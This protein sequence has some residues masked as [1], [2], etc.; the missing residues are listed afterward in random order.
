MPQR[1]NDSGGR[2]PPRHPLPPSQTASRSS[3]S[4]CQPNSPDLS[5]IPSLSVDY[6]SVDAADPDLKLSWIQCLALFGFNPRVPDDPRFRALA[7]LKAL[8]SQHGIADVTWSDYLLAISVYA[9]MA[10]RKARKHL[11]R[12]S[13]DSGSDS[14]AQ[15]LSSRGLDIPSALK[16]PRRRLRKPSR[17]SEGTAPSQSPR[18]LSLS[19]E[20]DSS[21]PSFTLYN[22]RWSL[23]E[24][25]DPTAMFDFPGIFSGRNSNPN[26]DESLFQFDTN[27]DAPTRIRAEHVQLLYH[28]LR[29][30]ESIYGL[31]LNVASAPGV[32]LTKVTDLGII[33][34][35]TGMSSSDILVSQFGNQAF[36][37]AHYVAVDRQIKAVVVCVRGTANLVDSLTDVAATHDPFKIRRENSKGND[38]LVE[39]FGHAGI[40]RSARNLFN[41]IR[42]DVLNAIHQNPGFEL[43]TTGHSL[44]ASTA[45]VLSLIMRDDSEFPRATAVCIAPPPCMTY[46]LAEQTASSTITVVNGSDIVPRLSVAVMLPYF[47]TARY[48]ADLSKSRKALLGL[49]LV[50]ST[51]DWKELESHNSSRV[52]DLKKYHDGR[53][54][55]I[56]GKVLQLVRRNEVSRRDV[57]K[58]KILGKQYVDVIPVPRTKFMQVRGREKGMF[59]AHAPYNYKG[60]LL[61][62]LRSM[63]AGPLRKTPDSSLLKNLLTIPVSKLLPELSGRSSDSGSLETLFEKLAEDGSPVP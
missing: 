27:E 15:E 13:S 48:V 33:C 47:A 22:R 37:P 28:M 58:N 38:D 11:K 45:S 42:N 10:D 46:E 36:L 43:L 34:R 35:R 63:G 20:D 5:S 9:T 17:S 18:R 50:R 2:K 44:G 4:L 32:S 12:D 26:T 51:I 6:E 52:K 40:L 16:R 24:G 25:F 1:S 14:S 3:A 57:L 29:H 23:P 31:P 62:A 19:L 41:K 54:L 59:L 61:M 21:R 56:P 30:A 53:R 49:G 60:S 39:G 7:K 55:F 8:T